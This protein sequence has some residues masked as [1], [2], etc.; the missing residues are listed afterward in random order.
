MK[1]APSAST[2]AALGEPERG[3]KLEN[4]LLLS[5]ERFL[6]TPDAWKRWAFEYYH[7][8]LSEQGSSG[9]KVHQVNHIYFPLEVVWVKLM[10]QW[11]KYEAVFPRAF[12]T[13]IFAWS[14]MHT[15]R[16]YAEERGTT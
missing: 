2:S 14:N 12:S 9:G 3:K 15:Q 5:A 4:G 16:C 10:V 6:L 7:P 8:E 1:S 13:H 11:K